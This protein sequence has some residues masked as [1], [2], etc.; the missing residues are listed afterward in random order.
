METEYEEKYEFG[1]G[2]AY[3]LGLFLAHAERGYYNDPILWFS[4]AADHLYDIC[5]DPEILGEDLAAQ[6]VDFRKSMLNKRF[7]FDITVTKQDID[8]AVQRAKDLLLQWDQLK[9][10]PC[11]R[12][13]YE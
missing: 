10:V 9:G 3:N 5:V 4:G 12:G 2:F 6:V 13:W 1:K 7:D 11:E 8:N